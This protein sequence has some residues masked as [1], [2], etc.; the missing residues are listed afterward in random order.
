LKLLSKFEKAG[1]ARHT[2]FGFLTA[3]PKNLGTTLKLSCDMNMKQKV[4]SE[5]IESLENTYY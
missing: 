4:N 3:S 1:Y 5:I 2:T